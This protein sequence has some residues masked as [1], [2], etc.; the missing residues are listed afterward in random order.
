MPDVR[1]FR[2]LSPGPFVAAC[3]VFRGGSDTLPAE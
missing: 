3:L 1:C 2:G